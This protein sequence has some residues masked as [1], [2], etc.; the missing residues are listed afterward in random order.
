MTKAEIVYY[1]NIGKYSWGKAPFIFT[2]NLNK[3][4]YMICIWKENAF[5]VHVSWLQDCTP[6]HDTLYLKV[7]CGCSYHSVC[8]TF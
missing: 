2:F 4:G 8:M 1:Y 5:Q 3:T 7:V 6:F